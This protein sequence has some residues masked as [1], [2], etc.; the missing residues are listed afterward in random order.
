MLLVHSLLS[1]QLLMR[2]LHCLP[3]LVFLATL[4]VGSNLEIKFSRHVQA[5]DWAPTKI[6]FNLLA[7]KETERQKWLFFRR[8]S[9]E[10]PGPPVEQENS[11]K[12]RAGVPLFQFELILLIRNPRY[13]IEDPG[14]L[15]QSSGSKEAQLPV[16]F[17]TYLLL[18][19]SAELEN[20]SVFGN[21][22]LRWR[23]LASTELGISL[24][25]L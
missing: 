18:S 24:L 15:L 20:I 11:R 5:T 6:F 14:T 8:A 22:L 9:R 3:L 4:A 17:K 12:V 16:G 10:S 19:S 1:P 25:S 7:S 21:L 23:G 2:M 13:W